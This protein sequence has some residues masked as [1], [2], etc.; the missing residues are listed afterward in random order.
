MTVMSAMKPLKA[1]HPRAPAFSSRG[2]GCPRTRRGR[3][4]PSRTPCPLGGPSR[5]VP[6]NGKRSKFSIFCQCRWLCTCQTNKPHP[7][8]RANIR[9]Q[10]R[11]RR[12]G[13][14]RTRAHTMSIPLF[15][16][17]LNE[18]EGERIFCTDLHLGP[19]D[20]PLGDGGL[21]I[22]TARANG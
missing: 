12:G 18:I 20:E 16:P 1:L 4:P 15:D 7:H 9:A 19:L 14:E 17:N 2:H 13:R 22:K 21:S 3:L 6:Q 10:Q 5:P 8:C 11:G